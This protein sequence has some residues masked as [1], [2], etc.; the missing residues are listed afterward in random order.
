M[1]CIM[2]QCD[3]KIRSPSSEESDSDNE[4]LEFLILVASYDTY[5]THVNISIQTSRLEKRSS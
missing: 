4:T 2:S 1:V 5:L 3:V